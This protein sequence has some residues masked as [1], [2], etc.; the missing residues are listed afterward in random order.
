MVMDSRILYN[1]S[2]SNGGGLY[3]EGDVAR[4][5]RVTGSCIM[6]NSDTS[7]V[8]DGDLQQTATGN[9]WGAA[10]G[11]NTAGADTVAGN[12]DTTGFLTA[13]PF[14]CLY[15]TI[16]LPLVLREAGG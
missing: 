3:H 1:T 9:W 2:S 15:N 11:P 6:G 5:T 4:T 12:V 13:I 8:N 14:H 16:Y 7:F 10:T